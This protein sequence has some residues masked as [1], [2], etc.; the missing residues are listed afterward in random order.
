[1]AYS[2]GQPNFYGSPVDPRD[3]NN[4]MQNQIITTVARQPVSIPVITASGSRYSSGTYP[5]FRRAVDPAEQDG[6]VRQLANSIATQQSVSYAAEPSKSFRSSVSTQLGRTS[7][8]LLQSPSRNT[9]GEAVMSNIPVVGGTSSLPN[10][11]RSDGS[12]VSIESYPTPVSS[13][14]VYTSRVVPGG[15]SGIAG[16]VAVAS[17]RR[18]VHP[19]GLVSDAAPVNRPQLCQIPVV[20]VPSETGRHDAGSPNQRVISQ[21]ALNPQ[22]RSVSDRS[23]RSRSGELTFSKEAEVD[24]LTD[25]LVQNMNVA[26]NPDFCGMHAFTF[27]F[28]SL[29]SLFAIYCSWLHDPSK[30]IFQPKPAEFLHFLKVDLV[31]FGKVT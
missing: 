5:G 31:R 25:L 17:S 27:P 20:V 19:Q 1:M 10:R 2:R 30:L 16:K 8:V 29:N 28:N 7:Q 18:A 12:V 14:V 3:G 22:S 9:S 4:R 11:R 24:A 26:G 23:T 6:P 21:A 13:Q 15:Q